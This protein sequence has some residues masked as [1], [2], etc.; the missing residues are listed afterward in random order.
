M[1]KKHINRNDADIPST[2]SAGTRPEQEARWPA[3]RNT[4][5]RIRQLAAAQR[6]HDARTFEAK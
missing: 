1:T 3:P 6:I 2:A 4:V 5:H